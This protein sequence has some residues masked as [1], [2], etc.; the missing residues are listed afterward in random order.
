MAGISLAFHGLNLSSG[1]LNFLFD[2]SRDL[3]C[4]AA[5]VSASDMWLSRFATIWAAQ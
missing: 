3:A 4:I 1:D 2:L 5:A